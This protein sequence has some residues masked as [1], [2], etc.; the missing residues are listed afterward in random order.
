MAIALRAR[1]PLSLSAPRRP[2]APR[3]S[4]EETRAAILAAAER[5]FAERG[6]EAARLEDIA[7][8][9]GVRRAAIFYYFPDKL[10]LYAAVLDDVLGD[11]APALPSGGSTEARLEA[12][13]RAWI[14][15]VAGRP[16]LARL[17]LREAASAQPGQSS[18][19]A[20]AG[21][22]L[23]DWLR[24]LIG[25]GVASGEFEPV[26]DPHRFVSL[27]GAATVF[28]FA[29]MSSLTPDVPFDPSSAAERELHKREMLDLAR[30]MLGISAGARREPRISKR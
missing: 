25:E 11:F 28:H 18:P 13:M 7:A 6:F 1:S 2:D 14:D 10:E 30:H 3:R 20:R 8:D 16:T 26:I 12:A 21:R 24:A 27:M 22:Q 19:L 17:M 9:V 4:G 23:V 29:S 5:H 15:Y